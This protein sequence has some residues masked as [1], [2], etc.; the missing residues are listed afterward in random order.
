MNT[1]PEINVTDIFNAQQIIK[2]AMERGTFKAEEY[3]QVGSVFDKLS[4]YLKAVQEQVQAQ[5]ESQEPTPAQGPE[6][7]EENVVPKKKAGK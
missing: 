4:Q 2:V 1:Q 3:S 5:Q 6:N 7:E